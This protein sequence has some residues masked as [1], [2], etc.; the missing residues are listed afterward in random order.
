[1]T[2]Q[3]IP[4]VSAD[5]KPLIPKL[6]FTGDGKQIAPFLDGVTSA[7]AML[8]CK[9]WQA[10]LHEPRDALLEDLI[11]VQEGFPEEVVKAFRQRG[12]SLWRLPVVP[13]EKIPLEDYFTVSQEDMPQ[14]ASIARLKANGGRVG[15]AVDVRGTV[16]KHIERRYTWGDESFNVRDFK[17]VVSVFR[18]YTNSDQWVKDCHI[19]DEMLKIYYKVHDESNH[20]G[21]KSDVCPTCPTFR[22]EHSQG[23]K[24]FIIRMCTGT[25]PVFKLAK[26]IEMVATPPPL[27]PLLP[28]PKPAPE[29]TEEPMTLCSCLAAFAEWVVSFVRACLN[30]LGL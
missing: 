20:T 6:N 19:G 17:G 18:R 25:D 21:S 8:V 28:K 10:K 24:E 4:A 3:A 9:L 14:G 7:K 29:K 16:D 22:T 13:T 30:Y 26:E 15:F 23:C 12:L 27:P 2:T 11:S 1:M 5:W